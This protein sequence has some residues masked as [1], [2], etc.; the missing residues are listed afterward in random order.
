MIVA[1]SQQSGAPPV[2]LPSCPPTS[3]WRGLAKPSQPPTPSPSRPRHTELFARDVCFG[4]M[5]PPW[6][7][8]SASSPSSPPV[9][10]GLSVPRRLGVEGGS[11]S[12]TRR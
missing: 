10:N 1:K 5:R 8:P 3:P 4:A 11:I 2:V 12:S 9:L 6:P 7:S